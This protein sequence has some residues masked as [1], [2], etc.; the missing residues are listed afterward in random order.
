[1]TQILKF[2]IY[3]FHISANCTKGT[4]LHQEKPTSNGI[5][6]HSGYEPS[7][8]LRSIKPI[9]KEIREEIS[10]V[11]TGRW[12]GAASTRRRVPMKAM[13]RRQGK[14]SDDRRKEQWVGCGWIVSHVSIH[15]RDGTCVATGGHVSGLTK[16]KVFWGG[17]TSLRVLNQSCR[18]KFRATL[19]SELCS[20]PKARQFN[21]WPC[22]FPAW[23][24]HLSFCYADYGY[25]FFFSAWG[26]EMLSL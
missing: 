11:L 12:R 18:G 23:L 22:V 15:C 4:I 26:W 19:E 14:S 6:T 9:N 10:V 7:C 3:L 13:K 25:L 2:T 16:W 8:F 5:K 1:M 17:N 24:I 21:R 20:G